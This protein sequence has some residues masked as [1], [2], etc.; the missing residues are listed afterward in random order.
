MKVSEWIER[1]E[2]PDVDPEA[3]LAIDVGAGCSEHL[4]ATLLL[5]RFARRDFGIETGIPGYVFLEL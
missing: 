5:S 2:A 3:E 4:D 1:L